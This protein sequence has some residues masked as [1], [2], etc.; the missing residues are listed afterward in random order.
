[1]RRLTRRSSRSWRRRKPRFRCCLRASRMRTSTKALLAQVA[2]DRRA[3]RDR[4]ARGD[5][6]RVS[7]VKPTTAAVAARNTVP[8]PEPGRARR[9]G[10]RAGGPQRPGAATPGDGRA[11]TV[12]VLVVVLEFNRPRQGRAEPRVEPPDH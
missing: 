7:R 5:E 4:V 6:G 11:G 1:M 3:V 8:P 12:T 2:A 10:P 9:E